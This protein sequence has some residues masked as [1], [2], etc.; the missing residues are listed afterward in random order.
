MLICQHFFLW[1]PTVCPASVLLPLFSFITAAPDSS[2]FMSFSHICLCVIFVA[3]FDVWDDLTEISAWRNLPSSGPEGAEEANQGEES[4]GT[5]ECMGLLWP[6]SFASRSYPFSTVWDN[7]QLLM[8][9]A[10]TLHTVYAWLSKA[11][12]CQNGLGLVV[13]CFIWYRQL[14][15]FFFLPIMWQTCFLGQTDLNCLSLPLQDANI[16]FPKIWAIKF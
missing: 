7:V 9:S 14:V 16:L 12:R 5:D 11:T 13:G 8:S 6:H 15:D 2:S 10:Y 3:A 4:P 1:S